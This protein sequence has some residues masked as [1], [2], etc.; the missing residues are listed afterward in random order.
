MQTSVEP[1]FLTGDDLNAFDL[2]YLCEQREILSLTLSQLRERERQ[3]ITLYYRHIRTLGR[4]GIHE[5]FNVL[6]RRCGLKSEPPFNITLHTLRH[7]FGSW[8]AMEGVPLR[9]SRS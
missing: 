5:S 6:V 9:R 1:A 4:T 3:I 7:T 2:C 8:L